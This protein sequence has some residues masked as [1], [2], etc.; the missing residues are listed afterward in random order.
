[1]AVGFLWCRE[2]AVQFHAAFFNKNKRSIFFWEKKKVTKSAEAKKMWMH[3]S[4]W[5]SPL[6]IPGKKN[7]GSRLEFACP[8]AK[9]IQPTSTQVK[10][11][12]IGCAIYQ[13]NPDR[14]PQFFVF[15]NSWISVFRYRVSH[16]ETYFMNWIWQIEICKLNF[17]WR[18]FWNPEVRI[19]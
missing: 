10:L 4:Q 9:A 14:L 17:I 18:W 2:I 6:M 11:G 1:M 19:F 15:F 7:H 8:S 12:W 16:I 5:F 3:R 13:T